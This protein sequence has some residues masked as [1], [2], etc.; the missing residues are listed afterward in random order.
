MGLPAPSDTL[1]GQGGGTFTDG[2]GNLLNE[3]RSGTQ[4]RHQHNDPIPF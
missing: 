4:E 2:I 1:L 3:L